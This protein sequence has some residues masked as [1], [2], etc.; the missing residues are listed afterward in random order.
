MAPEEPPDLKAIAA[1]ATHTRRPE[2]AVRRTGAPSDAWAPGYTL[3][4][5]AGTVTT[6]PLTDNGSPDWPTLFAYWNLDPT[7]WEIVEPVRTNAWEMP[8]PDGEL[9]IHRQYKAALIRRRPESSP[10]VVDPILERLARW[11][12]RKPVARPDGDA[13]FV[14][15]WAD[16]QVAGHGTV[17]EFVDRFETSLEAIAARA[18][19]AAR[20]G[21]TH[22]VVAFLGD[23]IEGIANAAYSSQAFEVKLDQ[24]TQVRLVRLAEAKIVRTLAPLFTSTTVV[25]VPG[26]HGRIAPKVITRPTDNLDLAAFEGMAEALTE[27]GFADAHGVT[28]VE[29]GDDLVA[30][31]DASGTSLLVCH[32][33]QVRGSADKL[34]G[35]WRD[36]AFTRLADADC[37]ALALFGHRH[38][39]RIEEVAAGRFVIQ[40]P[41][42]GGPSDWFATVGGGTSDP[43]TVSFRTAAGRWWDFDVS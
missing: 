41:T 39:L 9:R 8:G 3:D 36:V 12:P 4:G 10:Q 18:R 26:N 43:G 31:V 42:L 22:T 2:P 23:M 7:E 33:D 13:S 6:G 27:S 11:R 24:R 32:G 25:A 16:W 34:A 28:F 30:L 20:D 37:A 19:K 14:S 38:H 29:P 17:D 5:D 1:G 15:A 35:W 21:V 40:C